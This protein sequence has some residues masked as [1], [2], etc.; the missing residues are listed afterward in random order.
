MATGSISTLGI[1]SGLDLQD[2]LTQLKEVDQ[3]PIEKKKDKIT[4]LESQIEAFDSI[5]STLLSMRTSALD[6]SLGSNFLN[7][8]TSAT[9]SAIQVTSNAGA[10]EMSHN[11]QVEQL[12]SFSSWTSEGVESKN[13]VITSEDM[14]FSYKLGEE[15]STI[16]L[17]VEAGTTLQA[18]V[19]MIND[20]ESNPGITASIADTGFGDNPFKLVLRSDKTGEENRIFIESQMEDPSPASD[21]G[22]TINATNT[23]DITSALSNNAIVFQERLADGTLGAEITATISDGTYTSGADLAAAIETAMETASTASGNGIDYKV[24][25]DSDTEKF[26]IKENGSDLH[27]LNISWGDSS[28]ASALGFDAEDDVWKPHAGIQLTESSGA[29]FHPPE[30]DDKV[31][32]DASN[33][34][35]ISTANGN[36]EILFRERLADGSLGE[37]K[38]AT[39]ADGSYTSGDDLA[40]AIEAAMEDASGNGID[41]SVLYDSETRK[42]TIME[43]G[44]ELKELQI[45][46]ANSSAAST[47]GFDAET[48][49]YRPIDASLNAKFTVDNIAYQRQS[50]DDIDDVIQGLSMDLKEPG[51]ATIGV[52][53]DYEIVETALQSIIDNYNSLKTDL[54]EKSSYDIDT[55]E[56]GV[57]Y[58]KSAINRIDEELKNMLQENL[59]LNGDI[60]NMFDIGLKVDE[61]G[62]LSF[63]KTKLQEVLSKNAEDVIKF[64][65]GDS[66]EGIKGFGDLIY[67]KMKT[68]TGIDGLL[69]TET[70]STRTRIGKLEDQIENDTDIL[71]KRYDTLTMQFIEMDS[72]M[73]Q[74]QSQADFMDQMLNSS[75][76]DD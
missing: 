8:Q 29:G 5:K 54:D 63:D 19:T 55:G 34:A 9:G 3:Q 33:T 67:D 13:A 60:R 32:I 7:T 36:N 26:S 16:S 20:D 46:W 43:D 1:G 69:S 41:Y 14:N 4:A 62:T 66:D 47:L 28:A 40:I 51:N 52:E 73:R 57:L 44:S 35:D 27:E 65:T 23:L 64:F 25:Y 50:N 58:G 61:N 37:K 6:L 75:K 68:Y 74:M 59:N 48:D 30:S 72:Y 45:D 71:N 53:P 15:G 12:A 70:D 17:D 39:I 10:T 42:F 18:L 38:T 49:S 76:K 22:V 2:M 56:K 21:N 11:V 31:F 24:T